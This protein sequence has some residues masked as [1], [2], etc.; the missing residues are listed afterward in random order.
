MKPASKEKIAAVR[1]EAVAAGIPCVTESGGKFLELLCSTGS[2]IKAV[3]IGSGNGFASL[4]IVNAML[5]TGGRL[6]T[7]EK[8]EKRFEL[9]Y[10]NLHEYIDGG[11]VSL[12][13]ADALEMLDVAGEDIDF[14]FIDGMKRLYSEFLSSYLPKLK[15]GAFIFSDDIFFQGVIDPDKTLDRHRSIVRG[16]REYNNYLA[17]LENSGL[18]KNYLFD[19]ENG[20]AVSIKL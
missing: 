2:R 7:F 13:N 10:N 4:F 8:D 3:E 1:S 11:Y 15:T 18:I 19:F 6:I 5:K 16:L 12:Y 9:A 17:E 20:M 14:L